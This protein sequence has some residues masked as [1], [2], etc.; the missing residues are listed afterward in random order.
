MKKVTFLGQTEKK[1]RSPPTVFCVR[2]FEMHAIFILIFW[3]FKMNK[4]TFKKTLSL[5]VLIATLCSVMMLTSWQKEPL[6]INDSEH[7]IVIKTTEKSRDGNTEKLL[8]D[9]MAELKEKG[10]LDYTTKDGMVTSINGI[11]TPADFSYC[12]MLYTSDTENANDAWGTVEYEGKEYG[13]AILGAEA[14][15][16]KPDQLYIWVYKSF[17]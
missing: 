16:L 6:V 12:W 10:E 15:K 9:Y 3:R 11:E 7:C 2:F 8:I 13:S 14:L 4:N 17:N 5:F 1:Q